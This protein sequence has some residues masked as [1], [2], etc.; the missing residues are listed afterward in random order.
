MRFYLNASLTYPHPEEAQSAVSKDAQ[1]PHA[2]PG[3]RQEMPRSEII[4]CNRAGILA[5][6]RDPGVQ[7]LQGGQRQRGEYRLERRGD[8]GMLVQHRLAHDRGRRIDDLRA[9]VV[10]ERGETERGEL[11]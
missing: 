10:A 11:A 1:F 2:A 3:L 6:D 9:L 8:F 7:L 5:A 4:G